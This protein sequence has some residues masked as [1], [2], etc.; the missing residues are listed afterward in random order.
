MKMIFNTLYVFSPR[1]K[2]AKT[3][4]FS[5]GVNVVTSSQAD[6]TDRGKT[7]LLRSL[8]HALGA[9]A[10]FDS[11]WRFTYFN[12]ALMTM[13]ISFSDRVICLNCL[14]SKRSVF[15]A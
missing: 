9:D 7:V 3:V 1:E 5:E 4:S 8:Y 2:M 13:Y 15:L 10:Y 14:T 11:K 12:L 6:G